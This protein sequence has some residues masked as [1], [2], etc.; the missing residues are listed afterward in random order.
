M[1]EDLYE[2]AGEL[3]DFRR[4]ASEVRGSAESADGLV[5]A[6]VNGDG[7]L[8]ELGLDPRIFR[9]TDSEALAGKIQQTIVQA[10]EDATHKAFVVLRKTLLRDADEETADLVIDPILEQLRLRNERTEPW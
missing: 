7:A 8:V 9:T 5:T 3:R 2:L 6:V 1:A 4:S 10:T